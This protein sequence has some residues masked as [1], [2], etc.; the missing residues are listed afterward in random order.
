QDQSTRDPFVAHNHLSLLYLLDL[1]LE[2]SKAVLQSARLSVNR[3]GW[4]SRPI[5]FRSRCARRRISLSSPRR[6]SLP[7]F[8]RNSSSTRPSAVGRPTWSA[9]PRAR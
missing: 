3:N 4:A 6:V 8:L 1:S 2:D 7:P 5:Q 9:R